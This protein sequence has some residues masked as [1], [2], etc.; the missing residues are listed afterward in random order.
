[1][2]PNRLLLIMVLCFFTLS[3]QEA[4]ARYYDARAGR[5]LTTDP[6]ARDFPGTS[7]YA[8]TL[9]N[10]TKYTDPDGRMPILAPLAGVSAGV[11]IGGAVTIAVV[12]HAW[13]YTFNPSYRRA[14]DQGA[15]SITKAAGD[16]LNSSVQKVKETVSSV[17]EGIVKVFS[18]ENVPEKAE[19]AAPEN[20]DPYRGP[21]DRPVTVVDGQ[22]NAIPV[23]KGG[24]VSGSADGGWIQVKDSEGNP[25]GVRKDGG[26]KPK[27]HP[28]PRAQEPH[29]HRPD[30]NNPDGTPWLPINK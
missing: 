12:G 19:P 27:T 1:M 18:K 13:S 7:P 8:Y 22:G 21:V 2:K 28:D 10:P 29:G 26:H 4:E 3:H 6:R 23:A 16:A 25:T 30:V 24:Q 11:Y 5:F 9:N 15:T 17:A 20:A 14:V